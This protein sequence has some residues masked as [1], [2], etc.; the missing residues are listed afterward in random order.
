VNNVT[1]MP[2]ATLFWR[3]A[4]LRRGIERT[5]SEIQSLRE[6]AAGAQDEGICDLMAQLS[7]ASSFLDSAADYL[8]PEAEHPDLDLQAM[9]RMVEQEAR[10]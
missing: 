6:A 4:V 1:P 5:R 2:R 3:L 7:E 10:P 8:R 9:R